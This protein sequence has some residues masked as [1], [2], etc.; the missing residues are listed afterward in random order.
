MPGV[1][2]GNGAINFVTLGGGAH[3]VPPYAVVGVQP[4]RR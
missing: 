4:P 1:R 2:I 3:D